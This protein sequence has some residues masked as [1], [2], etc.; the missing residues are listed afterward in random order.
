[1]K[2]TIYLKPGNFFKKKYVD[3]IPPPTL[4]E[5]SSYKKKIFNT[6]DQIPNNLDRNALEKSI[7]DRFAKIEDIKLQN[8]PIL[9]FNYSGVFNEN[10]STSNYKVFIDL[11]TKT[12]LDNFNYSSSFMEIISSKKYFNLMTSKRWQNVSL[13][14]K[15]KIVVK[16]DQFNNDL[17]LFLFSDLSNIRNNFITTKKRVKRKDNSKIQR[18]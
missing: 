14:F 9:I 15:A 10:D 18:R 7:F 11:N 2:N 6:W 3:P 4:E 5:I 1:M 8:C 13:S 12:L 17:N 16:P